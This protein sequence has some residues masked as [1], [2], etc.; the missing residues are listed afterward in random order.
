MTV[1]CLR[2]PGTNGERELTRALTA[3]GE[4]V[5]S[6]DSRE[7]HLPSSTVRVVLPGGFSHGDALRAGALAARSPVMAAVAAHVRAGGFVLGICNGF[8]ILCEA[9]L[10][11]GVLLANLSGRFVAREAR[12]AVESGTVLAGYLPQ[13]LRLPIAHAA[14][15]YVAAAG[16][17]S[18]HAAA[19]TVVFRYAPVDDPN[20]GASGT[21]GLLGGPCANVL[22]LMPHPERQIDGAGPAYVDG[23][24]GGS[25]GR[26]FFEAI[27]RYDRERP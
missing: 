17:V 16:Y 2:F 21:A 8:Q 23:M 15:R 19:A 1:A 3:I 14:G 25:D 27:L 22:G 18:P 24:A 6:V 12:L 20:P 13:Q 10:L 7:T 11:P 4:R 26:L 5:V 9:G